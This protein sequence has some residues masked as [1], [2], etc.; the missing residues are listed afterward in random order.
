M[1]PKLLVSPI[2]NK[3]EIYQFLVNLYLS[4]ASLE[5]LLWSDLTDL[6]TPIFIKE[7]INNNHIKHFHLGE[8][9]LSKIFLITKINNPTNIPIML[10]YNTL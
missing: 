6:I 5:Q 3:L 10:I 7:N 2:D 1:T 8:I 9:L 4:E